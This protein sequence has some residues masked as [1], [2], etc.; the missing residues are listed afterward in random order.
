MERAE[1]SG[2]ERKEKE[3]V[4]VVQESYSEYSEESDVEGSSAES[5]LR[6]SATRPP[7]ETAV[8]LPTPKGYRLT[9]EKEESEKRPGYLVR[10]ITQTFT[11]I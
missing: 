10:T 3:E 1:G 11:R 4:E 9:G 8:N 6:R 7:F 2:Q 5:D